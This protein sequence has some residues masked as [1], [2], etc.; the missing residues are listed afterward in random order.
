M[1]FIPALLSAGASWLVISGRRNALEAKQ[2]METSYQR[3]MPLLETA[4]S[5]NLVAADV[6]AKAT[7]LKTERD[8]INNLSPTWSAED[9]YQ[10]AMAAAMAAQEIGGQ[11]AT[12][13][14]IANPIGDPNKWTWQDYATLAAVGVG[15][16]MGYRLLFGS[17]PLLGGFF[18]SHDDGEIPQHKLPRYAG[19]SRR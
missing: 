4:S 7:A 15:I 2:K 17:K 1:L 18:G 14:G 19:G 6:F 5:K 9:V 12:V 11:L 13:L 10:R 16:Y 3:L 8:A